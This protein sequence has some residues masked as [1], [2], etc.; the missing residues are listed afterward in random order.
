MLGRV[1][2]V[3]ADNVVRLGGDCSTGRLEVLHG[4]SGQ[5]C[6]GASEIVPGLFRGGFNAS[7]ALV[8]G[9]RAQACDFN[10]FVAYSKWTWDQ[11][12][13]EMGRGAWRI[14]SCAPHVLLQGLK[15]AQRPEKLWEEIMDMVAGE[16]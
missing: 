14:I 9:E 16:L 12:N 11:L 7:R 4:L 10:F 2:S 15:G 13:A 6:T 1:G 8:K 5:S 3:F